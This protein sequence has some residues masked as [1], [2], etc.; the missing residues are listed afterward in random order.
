MNKQ[1]LL[2]QLAN[3][4]V[5]IETKA[6]HGRG[7]VFASSTSEAWLIT[8]SHMCPRRSKTPEKLVLRI[9]DNQDWQCVDQLWLRPQQPGPHPDFVLTKLPWQREALHTPIDFAA[10]E[11]HSQ[12]GYYVL[13]DKRQWCELKQILGYAAGQLAFKANQTI[14][15]PPRGWSGNPIFYIR[16]LKSGQWT[17]A[18]AGVIAHYDP[19]QKALVAVTMAAELAQIRQAM[20]CYDSARLALTDAERKRQLEKYQQACHDYQQGSSAC[21]YWYAKDWVALKRP[22]PR[23]Q[24]KGSSG[25][26]GYEESNMIRCR[27]YCLE[28]KWINKG[29]PETL[30]DMLVAVNALF[31]Q[32]RQSVSI[33]IQARILNTVR[34]FSTEVLRIDVVPSS[35]HMLFQL[36]DNYRGP[37]KHE[38]QPISRVFAC[39]TVMPPQGE[40]V[41]TKDADYH[42]KTDDFLSAIKDS[43]EQRRSVTAFSLHGA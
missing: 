19:S 5:D 38:G 7:Y 4:V 12:A 20:L 37:Y 39:V 17:Q 14:N 28:R 18:V 34:M 24:K 9:D 36:Q 6:G 26:I 29:M 32:V 30:S 21:S 42:I 16:R 31:E 40:A 3:Q 35:S 11:L 25:I 33:P 13:D 2:S 27:K 23:K 41:F 8:N 22:Q 10:D 1:A 15:M 43:Q